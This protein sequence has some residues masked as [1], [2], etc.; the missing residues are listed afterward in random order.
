MSKPS[1]LKID[2]V[3]YVRADS[4]KKPVGF[5]APVNGVPFEIGS[6]YLI[7][8]VTMTLTGRVTAVIGPFLVLED[9]AW[10]ANTGRFSECIGEGTVEECEPVQVSVRVSIP[11]IVDA[12]DWTHVLPRN[13]K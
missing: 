1:T 9:A 7:R 2:D 12:Y 6:A 10:I 8:T 3:E 4:I 11:S 13:T 5:A